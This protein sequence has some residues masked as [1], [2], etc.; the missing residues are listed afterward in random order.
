MCPQAC[1]RYLACTQARA[2][3]HIGGAPAAG[4]RLLAHKFGPW[5]PATPA[6]AF[7]H[8]LGPWLPIGGWSVLRTWGCQCVFRGGPWLPIGSWCN[9]A[10][11]DASAS[12]GERD[13]LVAAVF[14]GS[15]RGV[16]P[17]YVQ[18]LFSEAAIV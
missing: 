7:V 6:F 4:M 16:F 11:G 9:C 8:R 2:Y 18:A 13:C 17:K 5:L 15:Q 3:V 10:D 1:L 12:T 14:G